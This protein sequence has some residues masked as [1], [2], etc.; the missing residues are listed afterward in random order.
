MFLLRRRCIRLWFGVAHLLR[1]SKSTC[2]KPLSKGICF[3]VCILFFSVHSSTWP[4]QTGFCFGLHK[5][6]TSKFHSSQRLLLLLCANTNMLQFHTC[7]F[8]SA[9]IH[10]KQVKVHLRSSDC[11]CPGC[12]RI[13]FCDIK[14]STLLLWAI[15]NSLVSP[16]PCH[17]LYS[18]LPDSY[19]ADGGHK[20]FALLPSLYHWP[21]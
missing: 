18:S 12:M 5:P 20:L 14:S 8:A 9:S 16:F 2:T 3:I 10:I 19:C 15:Q 21:F 6:L 4:P 1:R 7:L 17:P 11:R 13:V